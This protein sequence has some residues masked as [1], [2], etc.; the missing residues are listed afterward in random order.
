MQSDTYQLPDQNIETPENRSDE[1]IYQENS[2]QTQLEANPHL[3]LGRAI[4]ELDRNVA[5]EEWNESDN[6]HRKQAIMTSKYIIGLRQQVSSDPDK[7]G[8]N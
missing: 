3:G 1:S 2:R 8:W 5:S 4:A 6:R 7:T